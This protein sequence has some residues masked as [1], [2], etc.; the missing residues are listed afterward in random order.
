MQKYN[1]PL[2]NS[3]LY[4]KEK[5]TEQRKRKVASDSRSLQVFEYWK[6]RMHKRSDAFFDGQRQKAVARAL[7]VLSVEDCCLAIEGCA[8]TPH[9]MGKNPAGIKYNDLALIFR[10]A[11]HWERFIET[12]KQVGRSAAPIFSTSENIEAA[13]V[14]TPEQ[15]RATK[16]EQVRAIQ[17]ARKLVKGA[18]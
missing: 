9:N 5:E 3:M 12:A 18:R 4:S 6:Q 2:F 8:V 14:L 16:E 17:E 10:D 7:A 15:E 1:P 13:E 11:E